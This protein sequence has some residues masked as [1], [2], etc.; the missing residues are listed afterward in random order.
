MDGGTRTRSYRGCRASA[1][2][3]VAAGDLAVD[4]G[5]SY[6]ATRHRASRL[7][8]IRLPAGRTRQG[9][10]LER[11]DRDPVPVLR[12]RVPGARQCALLRRRVPNASPGA[13]VL[14]AGARSG[15]TR[16]C[17]RCSPLTGS[18]QTGR[19]G[20]TMRK[21]LH[22]EIDALLVGEGARCL[23]VDADADLDGVTG[24][25][26]VDA[27]TLRVLL[28][29]NGGEMSGGGPYVTVGPVETD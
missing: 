22:I 7:G 23:V 3:A 20:G 8:A 27:A 26:T 1:W 13:S 9:G 4:C 10:R 28:R 29:T 24:V 11:A 25:L 16:R 15:K 17:S 14:A 18:G 19:A 2:L 5:R 6:Y 12:R 21:H